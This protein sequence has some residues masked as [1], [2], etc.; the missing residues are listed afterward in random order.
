MTAALSPVVLLLAAGEGRRFGGAKQ[1]ADIAGEPMCR[2]VARL[3]LG[4]GLPVLVV[5]GAHADAVERA[6]L[7]LP[8]HCL[9][10]DGWRDGMGSSIAAGVRYL[11]EQHAEA[12]GVLICLADQPLLDLERLHGMLAR[13]HVAPERLLV[14]RHDGIASPPTLLPRDCFDELAALTGPS[15]ARSLIERHPTRVEFFDFAGGLDVDT[16][17]DLDDVRRR[18]LNPSDP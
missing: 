4:L 9:R 8:L 14:A 10:H 6:L 15:G 16:P 13:H 7:A 11:M 5:T 2:R 3:L 18:L 17:Q 12:S 1:L